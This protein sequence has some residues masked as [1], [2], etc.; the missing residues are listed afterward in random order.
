MPVDSIFD[1]GLPPTGAGLVAPAFYDASPRAMRQRTVSFAAKRYVDM[2]YV[3]GLD[4]ATA[5]AHVRPRMIA[6]PGDLTST[7]AADSAAFKAALAANR[8][9]VT[10][11]DATRHVTV[12]WA[13]PAFGDTTAHAEAHPGYGGILLGQKSSPDFTPTPLI[14]PTAAPLWRDPAPAP[15]AALAKAADALFAGSPGLYGVLLATP[16]RVIFERYSSFGRADRVTPSWSMTKS[17]TATTIARLLHQGWLRSVH[18]R[19][20]PPLWTDPRGIHAGI[21]L[22]DLLRM[23]S[24]L[25]IPVLHTDGHTTLGFENSMVYQDAGNAFTTAQRGIPATRPGQVFRYINA[26]PNVLGA[27]IRAEIEQRGLPYPAT[28]YGLLADRIGMDSFQY[29]ADNA[30][31]LIASGA[32]F[33]TLSDYARLG[34]L[35]LQ[36]GVWQGERILPEGWVSYALS[37]SHTGT[38]YAASFRTNQN[39]TFPSLPPDTARAAGASD[40]RIFVLRGANMVAVVTNETDSALNLGDLD[41]FL[42]TGIEV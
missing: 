40:Q 41:R 33:A 13:D 31:N 23:R 9:T 17:M 32:G 4:R 42:A 19:A 14:R 27:I 39:A 12:T 38:N 5:D 20:M 7:P 6:P 1:Q 8:F 22:D 24:G 37:S 35:Y 26:G 21:T 30:G 28:L 10:A 15:A 3:T 11:D 25:A 29:S 18:D 36:D 16:E 2:L 34:V